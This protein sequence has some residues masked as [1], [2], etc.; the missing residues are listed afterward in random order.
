M[1]TNNPHKAF[2][3][4]PASALKLANKISRPSH[5]TGYGQELALTGHKRCRC[6]MQ[7]QRRHKQHQTVVY[8]YMYI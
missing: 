7:L 6:L 1:W 4:C 3:S 2:A 8:M 5:V